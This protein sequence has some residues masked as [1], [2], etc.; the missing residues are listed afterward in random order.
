MT[1]E[2][3][4]PVLLVGGP[5]SELALLKSYLVRNNVSVLAC[6]GQLQE[7]LPHLAS[8]PDCTLLLVRPTDPAQAGGW[9]QERRGQGFQGRV[10]VVV[11]PEEVRAY[12]GKGRWND[13]AL[14]TSVS[15]PDLLGAA[16]SASRLSE[17]S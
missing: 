16:R 4:P 15:E 5:D 10:G 1:A 11:R 9:V 13:F 12:I 6:V 2:N 17:R 7:A 3:T 14:K 8:R